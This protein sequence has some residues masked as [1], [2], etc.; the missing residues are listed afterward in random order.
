MISAARFLRFTFVFVAVACYAHFIIRRRISYDRR[1]CVLIS[2]FSMGFIRFVCVL[3]FLL[4]VEYECEIPMNAIY[5]R[6][7]LWTPG[8]HLVLDGLCAHSLMM[9]PDLSEWKIENSCGGTRPRIAIKSKLNA[10]SW[11]GWVMNF[12]WCRCHSGWVNCWIRVSLQ[13]KN[14][15]HWYSIVI[16][17]LN[18]FLFPRARYNLMAHSIPIWVNPVEWFDVFIHWNLKLKPVVRWSYFW[19]RKNKRFIE[20]LK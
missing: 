1:Q 15:C 13:P 3:Y 18:S 17:D 12:H 10:L 7:A 6:L 16:G 11:I 5:L 19:H 8:G 2:S 4:L 9:A 20:K 14:Y